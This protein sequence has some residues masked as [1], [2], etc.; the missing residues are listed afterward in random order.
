MRRFVLPWRSE[1]QNRNA[2]A[3]VCD[4]RLPGAELWW[5]PLIGMSGRN[6]TTRTPTP[7]APCG[8]RDRF[9]CAGRP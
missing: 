9:P 6:Q 7:L 5:R 2:L 1:W 8:A 3:Q 4:L